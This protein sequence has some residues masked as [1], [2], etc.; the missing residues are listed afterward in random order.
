[1]AK[2]LKVKAYKGPGFTPNYDETIINIYCICR[3]KF[4]PYGLYEID[5]SNGSQPIQV[6]PDDMPDIWNAIGISLQ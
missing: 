3:I 1:M 2:F 5:L 6:F 4:L